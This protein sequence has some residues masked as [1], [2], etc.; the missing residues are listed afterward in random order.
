MRSTMS[1]RIGHRKI[2][3]ANLADR[4]LGDQLSVAVAETSIGIRLSSK[5][6]GINAPV[7]PILTVL[8]VYCEPRLGS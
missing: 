8:P 7:H 1:L 2:C 6:G 4:T 3:A 5:R